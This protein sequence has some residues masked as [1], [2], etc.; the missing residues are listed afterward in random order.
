MLTVSK[1]DERGEKEMKR[2][3]T[4]LRHVNSRHV[5]SG[6]KIRINIVGKT[7]R[8]RIQL[9]LRRIRVCLRLERRKGLLRATF[10]REC[11]NMKLNQVKHFV[12]DQVMR[13]ILNRIEIQIY[14]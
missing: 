7:R 1:V 3:E 2:I 12:I 10:R 4:I 9:C 11:M 8:K 14:V 6:D 5:K 13:H